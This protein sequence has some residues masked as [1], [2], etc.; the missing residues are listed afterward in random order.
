MSRGLGDVYKRQVVHTVEGSEAEFEYFEPGFKYVLSHD[1]QNGFIATLGGNLVLPLN[2]DTD[3]GLL[4]YFAIGKVI[5]D[6]WIFQGSSRLKL[7]MEDLDKNKLELAGIVHW[8]HTPWPRRVFPALEVVADIPFERGS[9][10]DKQSWAQ[11]SVVPQA[12]IGLNKRGHVALNVG[13]ELPLN[14]TERYD[15]QA[16]VYLIW[17]FADGGFFE[18][19]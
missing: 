15:W 14:D 10:P 5:N 17:D 7:N 1:K 18:A 13:V 9:G 3:W 16:Y 2:S 11:W 19:W 4:P 8:T 6:Q 12:R